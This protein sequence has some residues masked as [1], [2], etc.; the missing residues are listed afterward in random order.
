MLLTSHV[1]VIRLPLADWCQIRVCKSARQVARPSEP[2]STQLVWLM[3]LGF[4]VGGWGKVYEV[5]RPQATR[6]GAVLR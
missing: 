6:F 2:V 3:T 4:R 1:G 5:A